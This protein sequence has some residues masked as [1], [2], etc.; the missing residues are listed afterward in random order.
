MKWD[1]IDRGKTL[2]THGSED[3]I[4]LRDDEHPL[5]ARITLERDG[6]TA[7]YAITCGIYGWMFHT[8]FLAEANAANLEFD[9]MKLGLEEILSIIPRVD[10]PENDEKLNAVAK[11]I[12]EFVDKYP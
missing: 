9:A 5:G 1:Q 2:G 4:I 7:P 11:R 12:G 8:R 3:G 6:T 10:E